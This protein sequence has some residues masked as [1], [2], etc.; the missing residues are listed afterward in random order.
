MG[1]WQ[2]FVRLIQESHEQESPYENSP[3]ICND[4]Q[5]GLF[6]LQVTMIQGI[7]G[8]D[9]RDIL[10]KE[11]AKLKKLSTTND[12]CECRHKLGCYLDKV[13][14]NVHHTLRAALEYDD[15]EKGRRIRR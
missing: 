1:G 8:D 2:V 14:S 12:N 13:L 4:C 15:D 10:Q 7:L 3:Y 11:T 6:I 5:P 9:P